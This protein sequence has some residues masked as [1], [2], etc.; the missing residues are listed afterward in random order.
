VQRRTFDG[1]TERFEVRLSRE[2]RQELDDLARECDL[3][4]A[5]VARLA[6]KWMV[7]HRDLLV[8]GT[9]GERAA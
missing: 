1:M 3:S 5:D 7:E 8:R 4:A 6:I 9:A 2:R